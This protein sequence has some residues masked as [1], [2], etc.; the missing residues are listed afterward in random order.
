VTKKRTRAT[1]H[2][3]ISIVNALATHKGS[4]LGI[5][6]RVVAQAELR[7][8]FGISGSGQTYGR[9]IR[10]IIYNTIPK[11]ILEEHLVHIKIESEIPIGFGLKSSSAVSSAVALAC[12]ALINEK[13]EDCVVLDIATRASLDAGVSITGAYD[14]SSAC[15]YGGFV[16]TDN[17][18]N[19]LFVHEKAPDD[20]FAVI[21]MPTYPRGNLTKIPTMSELFQEAF[22]LAMAGEYWKAMNLNG[23]LLATALSA[24]YEPAIDALQ[25]GALAASISGNGPA[26]AAVSHEAKIAEIRNVFNKFDGSVLV[27]R[28]NNEKAKV[29]TIIG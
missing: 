9:L 29:D 11:Q 27:S 15:F 22:E 23:R 28:I 5:S 12:T 10:N 25:A 1:L 20:L 14:D 17:R 21:F 4:A 18:V 8:G 24:E 13:V 16:V 7:A 6:L 3:A 26:I 2:G 19:K